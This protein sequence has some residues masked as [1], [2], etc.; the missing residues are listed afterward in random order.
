MVI[1]AMPAGGAGPRPAAHTER[2][3]PPGASAFRAVEGV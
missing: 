1:E 3:Q 2:Q